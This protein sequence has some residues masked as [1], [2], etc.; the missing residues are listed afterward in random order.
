MTWETYGP[1]KVASE[2]ALREAASSAG[3]PLVRP[4]FIVGPHDPTDRFT[5]W[6]RRAAKGGRMLA[7]EP[8]GPA[9]AV[10]RCPRP[11]GVHLCWCAPWTSPERSTSRRRR[12]GTPC[13]RCWKRRQRRAA[14]RSTSPGATTEFIRA[15]GLSVTEED[16]PFP[17]VVPDEPNGHLFDTSRAV[18]AGLT[19]RTLSDTVAR[20]ARRRIATAA[21]ATLGAG[22]SA[23]RER[24]LLEALDA[25]S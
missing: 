10:D 9:A 17:L 21:V 23:A 11:R 6:V 24:E 4:H 20:H 18:A 16:D 14:R 15:H 19:F 13:R 5:Y 25:G 7:P 1:L 12:E 3:A 2:Y 8:A 22:L